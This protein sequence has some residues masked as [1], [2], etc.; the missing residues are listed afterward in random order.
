MGLIYGAVGGF[1][2]FFYGIVP[3][4]Q[5]THFHMVYAAYGSIF[6]VMALFWGW[7]FDGITPDWFDLLGGII[8]IFGVVLIFYAP[9]KGERPIWSR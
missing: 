8:A 6:I 3:T 7:I 2:L 5:S 1:V 9:R 4:F